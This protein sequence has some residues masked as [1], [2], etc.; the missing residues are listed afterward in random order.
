MFMR[1]R[2][3]CV[4]VRSAIDV[5]VYTHGCALG[6]DVAN[7]RFELGVESS[8]AETERVLV[9]LRMLNS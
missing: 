5:K 1:G 9:V 3:E 8:A 4:C 7:L 6:E 2:V